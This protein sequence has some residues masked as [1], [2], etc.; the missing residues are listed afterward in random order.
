M[1]ACLFQ[2]HRRA[3]VAQTD[4]NLTLVFID[5]CQ[6][7]SSACADPLSAAGS[8]YNE[9]VSVQS[10]SWTGGCVVYLGKRWPQDAQWESDLVW[11][12]R[13]WTAD[14]LVPDNRELQRSMLQQ[15]RAAADWGLRSVGKVVLMLWLVSVDLILI[16]VLDKINTTVVTLESQQLFLMWVHLRGSAEQAHKSNI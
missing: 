16:L 1:K 12:C 10:R 6:N 3:T 8:A 2:S 5:S 13:T 7:W 15:V 11:T 14:V 9:N 4:E